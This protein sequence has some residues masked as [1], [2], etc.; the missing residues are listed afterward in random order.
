MLM[1]LTSALLFQWLQRDLG[2][3]KGRLALGGSALVLIWFVYG[4]FALGHWIARLLPGRPCVLVWCSPTMRQP[5][6]FRRRQRATPRV[7]RGDG[8]NPPA[9]RCRGALGGLAGGA[10]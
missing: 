9:V 3:L 5:G 7:S 6:V 1:L 4:W 10:L 8:G 2:G